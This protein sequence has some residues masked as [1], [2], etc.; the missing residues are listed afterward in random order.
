[1]K[2]FAVSLDVVSEV[3]TLTEL[4]SALRHPAG[5]GSHSQGDR[6]VARPPVFD[7]TLWSLCSQAPATAPLQEHLGSIKS[8]FPPE[9]L[10]ELSEGD[11]SS[12]KEVFIDIGVFFEID[13]FP[14]ILLGLDDLQLI[15]DYGASLRVVCYAGRA[16]ER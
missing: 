6:R 13:I 15:H 9:R 10:W 8:Q 7:D 1:M 11:R 2:E 16:A 12:I 3:Q 4:S 5:W 14:Q